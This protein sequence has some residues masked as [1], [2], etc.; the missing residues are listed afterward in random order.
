M[1]EQLLGELGVVAGMGS[2]SKRPAGRLTIASS[3]VGDVGLGHDSCIVVELLITGILLVDVNTLLARALLIACRLL[4]GVDGW[5][6]RLDSD[7]IWLAHSS[8]H[9]FLV[10]KVSHCR[11]QVSQQVL[12]VDISQDNQR[13]HRAN[14]TPSGLLPGIYVGLRYHVV[15][16]CCE[17]AVSDG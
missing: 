4:G 16:Q 5:A 11:P 7:L 2:C 6:Q 13:Q 9:Q 14:R 10:C 12:V 3:F 15:Q 8:V 17:K 1:E